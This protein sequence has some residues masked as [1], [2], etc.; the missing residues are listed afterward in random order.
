MSAVAKLLLDDINTVLFDLDGTLLDTAPDLVDA[1]NRVCAERNHPAPDFKLACRYVSTGAAGLIR[2]AFPDADAA[3]VENLR[4]RL[5]DL[6]AE[7]VCVLTKPYP[8]MEKLLEQIE[9]LG[10]TWGVVTNKP[11]ALT[12]PL[13]KAIGLTNRSACIVS[14]DT[15]PQRKPDPAP[16]MHALD[17]I[18]CLPTVALY[19]GDAPQD[20]A[21]GQAAGV[22]T[23][24]V[25]WGYIIPGHSPHEWGA[26]Y[27]IDRPEQ[28]LALRTET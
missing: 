7:N 27:T 28:L 18:D 16:I 14:G 23:I 8:G 21:A 19:V 13:M 10:K 9:S 3:M 17:L 6:Y 25:S 15:L 24:A 1:L 5:V 4:I 12:E 26:D 22:K 11:A 2:L 20:I